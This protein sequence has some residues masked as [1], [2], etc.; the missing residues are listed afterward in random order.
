MAAEAFSSGAASGIGLGIDAGGTYTDA[1][2]FD[3]SERRVLAKAK[4]LTTY[5]NL[6]EGIRGALSQL[7]AADLRRVEVTSLSTTLATNAI[8]EGRGHKVGLLVLAPWDWF[9]EQIG[10]A[11]YINLPGS[12]DVSGDILAPLDE[13]ACRAAVR[14]L[15]EEE[16]CAALVVAGYG[17]I[18][19]PSQANRVRELARETADVPVVCAHEVCRRLNA[20]RAAQTA[21][22]NARLLPVVRDLMDAVRVALADCRV[23]GHLL[24]VKGD[25]T[26]VDESVARMR[27]IE[28][29]LSGPAASVSGAKLLTGLS[30]ALVMDIGG[31]TTDCAVLENGRVAVAPDG[32]RIGPWLMSV[33]VVEMLTVGLGGDSRLDFTSSRKLVVGPQRVIPLCC[34][35]ARFP[36]IAHFLRT[37]DGRHWRTAA[38]AGALDVLVRGT[39]GRL[40]L[41]NREG[42]LLSLLEPGPVPALE[43]ASRLGLPFP[44]LSFLTRRLEDCGMLQRGALT[45]TDLLHVRGDY[46]RWDRDAARRALEVFAAMYG[47]SPEETMVEAMRLVTRRL[48]DE[49]IR[50]EVSREERR[51]NNLPAHWSYLLDRAFSADG[52]SLDV[53]ISL[54][55]PIVGLGAPAAALVP[56]LKGLLNVDVIVPEHADVANAVGAIGA[57]ISVREE[58]VIQPGRSKYALHGT[59]ERIEFD[60][61]ETATARA[62]EIAEMRS[63]QRALEAGALSPVVNVTRHDWTVP[64]AKGESVF[65]ERRVRAVASGSAFAARPPR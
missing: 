44:L 26:S 23:T 14:R 65:L 59:D 34:L 60:D 62:M 38:N 1:V 9:A 57:Y 47:R 12:V 15:V 46:T 18:S 50:R 17:T 27:P 16:R 22:A 21:V 5:H 37:L 48:F 24:V 35:A 3:L 54:R 31:T 43:A 28:T 42:A 51:V 39:P 20:V 52:R 33:D 32:A 49:A 58:V 53:R 25:G 2:L 41:T 19:N 40:A 55:R 30:D 8:V 36:T 29:I 64:L 45:P 11:P 61:L 10:H 13:E 63:R 6:V 56:P 4:S 7:P